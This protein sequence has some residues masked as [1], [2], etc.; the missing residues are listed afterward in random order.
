MREQIEQ[1]YVDNFDNYTR[2]LAN[3]AGGI[4]NAEDIVQEAFTR[5][6]TYSNTYNG[7]LSQIQ[8]WFDRIL[9]RALYDF[10]RDELR[11]GM[12]LNMLDPEEPVEE[13]PGISQAT[14]DE[15]EVEIGDRKESHK[16]IL[17]LCFIKGYR[18]REIV[19]I[20]D[21]NIRNI[22]LVIDRFKKEMVDVRYS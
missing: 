20:I 18:P 7:D 13:H 15:L 17:T 5:A 16:E 19:E 4:H 22:Y 11:Q 10:K 8:T 2:S 12:T 9:R 14:L 21:D 6:L 3:R 1:L